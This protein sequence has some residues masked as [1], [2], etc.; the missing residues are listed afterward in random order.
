MPASFP[1]P[2]S[3][4]FAQSVGPM[5][6][7]SCGR[8]GHN[9]RSCDRAKAAQLA[10]GSA[11]ASTDAYEEEERP[12]TSTRKGKRKATDAKAAD[13][14]AVEADPT[15]H[16]M[17]CPICHASPMEP[18]IYQTCNGG[19]HVVCTNCWPTV[20]TTF[21]KCPQCRE[22]LPKDEIRCRALPASFP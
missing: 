9:I 11:D 1:L 3:L 5:V 22:P 2:L 12:S 6:C 10:A 16:M 14:Q 13:G 17:K 8:A 20:Q 15:T 19:M 4:A 7:S 18:P 21:Q